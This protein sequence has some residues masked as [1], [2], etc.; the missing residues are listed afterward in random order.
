MPNL[1]ES[2]SMCMWFDVNAISRRNLLSTVV[3]SVL[4]I[5]KITFWMMNHFLMFLFVNFILIYF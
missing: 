5:I 4:V 2:M 3:S 1:L